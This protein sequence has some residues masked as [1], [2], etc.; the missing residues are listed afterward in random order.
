MP[1]AVFLAALNDQAY[2]ALVKASLRDD[3]R[4]AELLNPLLIERT[5]GAL[6]HMIRSIDR[7]KERV[8]A[9]SEPGESASWF[10]SVGKLRG[11]VM[12]RL[13]PLGAPDEPAEPVSSRKEAKAWRA[14]SAKLA[15]FLD[16]ADPEALDQIKAP[17]GDL[18]ARQWLIA[19]EGKKVAAS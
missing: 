17:Y 16:V 6:A 3:D 4:W 5:R 14:F 13:E 2:T 18:T 11:Y 15:A 19:R 1:S 12:A 7:Q 10:A 9:T 8:S